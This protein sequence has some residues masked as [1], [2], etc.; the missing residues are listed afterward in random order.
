[1]KELINISHL[2]FFHQKLR[3]LSQTYWIETEG[4]KLACYYEFSPDN[5]KTIICFH[6]NGEAAV[7]YT[8]NYLSL[9]KEYRI[10]IL[11]AEY[12]GYGES[13]GTSNLINCI[14][15]SLNI[16]KFL[17][18]KPENTIIYGRSLGALPAIHLA[19]IRKCAG[20]IIDNGI[21]NV[22]AWLTRIINHEQME[23]GHID[24][25]INQL[26]LDVSNYF[27]NELKIMN[28]SESLLIFHTANETYLAP[29][30][31]A[32]QLNK[33]ANKTIYKKFEILPYGRHNNSLLMNMESYKTAIFNFMIQTG[34]ARKVINEK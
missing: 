12:R 5:T 22:I 32:I 15:D 29:L 4:F 26:E 19:T 23:T 33:S 24:V 18:L 14:T 11:I 34:I 2:I 13:T 16:F 31:H 20:L 7:D 10:N 6:G 30:K 28:Y 17:N 3:T 21:F 9:F 25:D 27:N 1:M 8:S